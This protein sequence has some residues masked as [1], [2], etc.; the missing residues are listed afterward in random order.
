MA[1]SWKEAGR[2][3]IH[4]CTCQVLIPL[5]IALLRTGPVCNPKA[6]RSINKWQQAQQGQLQAHANSKLVYATL[7][8]A[9]SRAD[10][11]PVVMLKYKQPLRSSLHKAPSKMH[12]GNLLVA[13]AEVRV[14]Q[15]IELH[16]LLLKGLH[17]LHE[18]TE[19]RPCLLLLMLLSRR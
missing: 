10:A 7:A 19:V 11:R 2:G 17:V 1:V 4:R 9:C 16:Q 8:V 5:S 6:I 3:T 15:T 14:R 13:F 12:D 18:A